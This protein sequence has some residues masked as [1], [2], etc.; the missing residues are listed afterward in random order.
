[1]FINLCTLT[2]LSCTLQHSLR[3]RSCHCYRQFRSL[4][5]TVSELDSRAKARRRALLMLLEEVSH[6]NCNVNLNA[7][8][9]SASQHRPSPPAFERYQCQTNNSN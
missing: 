7:A 3:R 1:M 5:N 4:M 8:L 2:Q 9:K 6:F